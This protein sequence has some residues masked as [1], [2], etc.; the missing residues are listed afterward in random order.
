[1]LSKSNSQSSN[2]CGPAIWFIGVVMIDKQAIVYGFAI[3]DALGIPYENKE[4]GTFNCTD[5]VGGGTWSQPPGTWS[6]DT[7]LLLA[8]LFSFKKNNFQL[9]KTHLFASCKAWFEKDLFACGEHR[10]DIGNTTYQVLSTN[11]PATGRYTAG[12]ACLP[13]ALGAYLS[14]YN[15]IKSCV[16]TLFQAP[17]SITGSEHFVRMLENPYASYIYNDDSFALINPSAWV[18]ET[19]NTAIYSFKTTNSYEECVLK[20]INYGGDT[21]SVGAV[22]GA[23]A[24]NVYGFKSIPD[25]W[26]KG[27]RNKKIIEA[28]L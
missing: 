22:A 1:M 26:I 14:G 6:D 2:L 15:D 24:A 21:D 20:A 19:I 16:S 11:T 23:L 28:C 13:L 7:S 25:R 10:F 9:N 18:M 4:Y 12:N 8:T 27:L 17:D 5:M 3:G